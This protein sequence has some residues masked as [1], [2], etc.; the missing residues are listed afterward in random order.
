MLGSV[1]VLINSSV[2][3][4]FFVRALNARLPP[5]TPLIVNAVDPGYCYSELRRG[6]TGFMIVFDYLMERALAFTTEVG[7]R[8]LVWV[9]LAYPDQPDKLRGEY[10]SGCEVQEV[11]DYVL[12]AQGAKAQDRLWFVPS[13]IVMYSELLFLLQGRTGGH[14]GQGGPKGYSQ[15]RQ[16]PLAQHCCVE[17]MTSMIRVVH[18][19]PFCSLFGPLFAPFFMPG[20]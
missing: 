19:R 18:S 10:S 9:A 4:V 7:S 11:S 13:K 8:R 12:S 6:L 16:L 5:S 3:N 2:L 1:Q 20:R 17:F 14:I 15:R